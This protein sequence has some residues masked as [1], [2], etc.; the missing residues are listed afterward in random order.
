MEIF[1]DI[2]GF[3]GYYQISNLGNVKS[4]S[5]KIRFLH[6]ISKKECVRISKERF[7]K[8]SIS[9]GYYIVSLNDKTFYLHRLI[10]IHFIDNFNNLPCINHKD[11][12][13]LN[14]C[15]DNLEWVTYKENTNHAWLNGRCESIREA[16]RKTLKTNTYKY[17][18]ERR[19][20]KK[21]QRMS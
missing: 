5:R 10:A 16:A 6:N 15:I 18:E 3:E 8:T 14:N 11:S 1:K 19:E 17:N 13:R 21:M 20:R 12:N 7:L 2:I 4:L 9:H